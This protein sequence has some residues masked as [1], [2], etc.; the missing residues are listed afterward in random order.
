MTGS[1]EGVS[2]CEAES[3]E[4]DI[5]EELQLQSEIATTS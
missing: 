1:V 2:C 4:Y 5:G 3:A